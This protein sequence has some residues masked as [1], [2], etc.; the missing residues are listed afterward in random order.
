MS[1]DSDH[2]KKFLREHENPKDNND[3]S[4]EKPSAKKRKRHNILG[5]FKLKKIEMFVNRAGGGSI[6][7][8]NINE[9]K[10]KN[11]SEIV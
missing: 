10:C 6:F 3:L 9:I 8:Q 4:E 7:K 1:F 2:F 11:E 5:D